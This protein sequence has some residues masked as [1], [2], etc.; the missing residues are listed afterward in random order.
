MGKNSSLGKMLKSGNI[1]YESV[2]N[3]YRQATHFRT[4]HP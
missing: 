3:G 4:K 1:E 2:K